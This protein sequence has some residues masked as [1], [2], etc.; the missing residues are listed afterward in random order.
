MRFASKFVSTPLECG[1]QFVLRLIPRPWGQPSTSPALKQ[2]SNIRDLPV[3]LLLMI[4]KYLS[5]ASQA[6]LALTCRYMYG[7]LGDHAFTLLRRSKLH[8]ADFLR[9]FERHHPYVVMCEKCAKYHRWQFQY[10][11][12]HAYTTKPLVICPKSEEYGK[13]KLRFSA[14]TWWH[15]HLIMRAHRCGRRFGM[16]VNTMWYCSVHYHEVAGYIWQGELLL[17]SVDT[18]RRGWEQL[19]WDVQELWEIQSPT[20]CEHFDHWRVPPPPKIDLRTIPRLSEHDRI[21]TYEMSSWSCEVCPSDYDASYSARPAV[22]YQKAHWL[23][24]LKRYTRVGRCESPRDASWLRLTTPG[25]HTVKQ[26][27]KLWRPLPVAQGARHLVRAGTAA[28]C[29]TSMTLW[30]ILYHRPY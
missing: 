19:Q 28:G 6:S 18:Y 20:H 22:G 30:N 9:F 14:V 5:S 3:E 13:I 23:F 7:V 24:V 16:S 1:R 2:T 26:K 12:L 11:L 29:P 4:A 21:Q 25:Y 15:V 17:E 27:A 8:T 10:D